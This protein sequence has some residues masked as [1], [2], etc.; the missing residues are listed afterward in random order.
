MNDGGGGDGDATCWS[1]RLLLSLV[2]R[3]TW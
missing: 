3:L 2:S 1:A